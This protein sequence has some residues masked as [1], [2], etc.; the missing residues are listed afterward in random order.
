VKSFLDELS[1]SPNAMRQ[2]ASM[3]NFVAKPLIV[4]TAGRRHDAEW[5]AA[6]DK[7][8]TLSTN[9]E[10][11]GIDDA[12]HESLFWSQPMPLQPLRPFARSSRRSGTPAPSTRKAF[13]TAIRRSVEPVDFGL[14]RGASCSPGSRTFRSDVVSEPTREESAETA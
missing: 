9:S 6:Q 3:V 4:V 10:H 1:V 5:M 8:A 12:A 11:R 2:A 7:L 14:R 13:Q